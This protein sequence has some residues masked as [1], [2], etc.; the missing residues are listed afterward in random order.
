MGSIGKVTNRTRNAVAGIISRMRK[1]GELLLE[2]KVTPPQPKVHLKTGSRLPPKL[3]KAFKAQPFK[4]NVEKPRR[5]R[6]RLI[7]SDTAVTLMERQEHQCCWP[8]GDPKQSDFRYCGKHRFGGK[9]YCA[10]HVLKSGRLYDG[11]AK[12]ALRPHFSARLR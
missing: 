2:K 8:L 12:K 4:I 10:E 7:N 9:P 3:P 6:L 5:I 11:A 1:S